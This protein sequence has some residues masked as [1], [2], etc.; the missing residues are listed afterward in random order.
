MLSCPKCSH[1][2]SIKSGIVKGWCSWSAYAGT[3]LL[4][5]HIL[6]AGTGPAPESEEKF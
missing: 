1:N 5:I 3:D 6:T 2:V 4:T